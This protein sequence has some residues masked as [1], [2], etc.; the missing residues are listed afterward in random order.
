MVRELHLRENEIDYR[1][2][3]KREVQQRVI[4]KGVLGTARVI[5]VEAV[6][7]WLTI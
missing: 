1:A 2:G 3:A 5:A 6:S 4:L 7:V